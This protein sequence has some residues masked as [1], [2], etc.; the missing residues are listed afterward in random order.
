MY[1]LLNNMNQTSIKLGNCLV[2]LPHFSPGHSHH[3]IPGKFHP[4]C[5]T[6]HCFTIIK[7][8]KPIEIEDWQ[9]IENMRGF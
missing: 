6:N 9:F 5:T 8:G 3:F 2:K 4:Y 7:D 1:V